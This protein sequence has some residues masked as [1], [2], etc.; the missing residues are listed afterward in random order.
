[1]LNDD[2]IGDEKKK[3]DEH[4]NGHWEGHEVKINLVMIN[5]LSVDYI[6]RSCV[7][8]SHLKIVAELTTGINSL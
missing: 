6:Y 4:V 5:I 3:H 7:R 8:N 1:M 2:D